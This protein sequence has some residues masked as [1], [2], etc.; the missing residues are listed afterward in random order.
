MQ[1]IFILEDG[2]GGRGI[3]FPP[4]SNPHPPKARGPMLIVGAAS[5]IF[6]DFQFIKNKAPP[7]WSFFV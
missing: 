4:N 6:Q 5:E 7:K 2:S 3:H 1:K